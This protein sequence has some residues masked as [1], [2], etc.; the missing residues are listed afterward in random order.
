M[1]I[2]GIDTSSPPMSV[3]IVTEQAVL[4]ART[5]Q[6]Q[7]NRT[8][9]LPLI[10]R[11]FEE[12]AM[13]PRDIDAVAVGAGPG[14]FTGLRVGM[15]TAK[16]IAF[17][18]AR[19]LWTVSSLAALAHAE[20]E[21]DPVGLVIGVLDARRGEIYA[22]AYRRDG[23]RTVLVGEERVLPPGELGTLADA[24]RRDDEPVRYTGDAQQ[25]YREL[26]GLPGTWGVTPSGAAV[27]Q[28]ALAGER[29]DALR[30]GAPSYIRPSEAEVR[31][32]DGVPGALRPR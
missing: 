15:A 31:Y 8:G 24:A 6:V 7:K 2:L 9:V 20:L 19:P 17:A 13:R 27:A 30:Q 10:D 26:A 18:A 12:L 3:A 32:P 21:R 11:L 1:R 25:T 23:A 5:E 14:S 4:G 29:A 28:L 22:G 16:G